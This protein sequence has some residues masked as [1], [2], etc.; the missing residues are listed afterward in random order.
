MPFFSQQTK[1]TVDALREQGRSA[2]SN[3]R[4]TA[5]HIAGHLR[6]VAALFGVELQEYAARQTDRLVAL[7]V[8][9]F[10]AACGYL[11][12]CALVCLLIGS[13]IGILWG[14]AVVCAAH[15]LAAGIL[16]IL[17]LNHKPGSLAPAT[18]QE[19]KNDLRCLQI[20]L[21]SKK[22]NC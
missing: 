11:V 10:L 2:A 17:A 21:D 16:I 18:R 3:M 12:L 14:M 4:D 8:G 19:L 7:A 9:I 22:G 15:F 5:I 6:A 1:E 20:L 13:C